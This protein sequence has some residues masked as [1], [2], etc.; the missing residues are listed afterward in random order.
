MLKQFFC[1]YDHSFS[2]CFE[3]LKLTEPAFLPKGLV[4][5]AIKQIF[6]RFFH[7]KPKINF[8][9]GPTPG[10]AGEKKRLSSRDW[11]KAVPVSGTTVTQPDQSFD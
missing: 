8:P 9:G 2:I 6:H 10:T 11:K 7:T 5:G 1:C 4:K 3:P